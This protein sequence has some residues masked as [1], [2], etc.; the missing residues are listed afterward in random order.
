MK[1]SCYPFN[2]LVHIL[3]ILLFLFTVSGCASSD[4]DWVKNLKSEETR[5]KQ[6][7]ASALFKELCATRAGE[8]IY[9]TTEDVEGILL[10]KVRPTAAEQDRTDQ[11][12]PGAAFV[13]EWGGEEYI[14]SFLKYERIM[15]ESPPPE[16]RGRG[17]GHG[18]RP[19]DYPKERGQLT[20]LPFKE[21]DPL[22]PAYRYVDVLAPG[23]TPDSPPLRYRYTGY[24]DDVSKRDTSYRKGLLLFKLKKELAPDPTPRYAVTY[25][26]SLDPNE[27]QYWIAGSTVKVIDTHTNTVMGE[28]TRYVYDYSLGF[29]GSG[30]Y[31]W[32]Q[33]NRPGVQCPE[34]EGSKKTS[35]RTRYFVDQVLKPA[36]FQ[37]L[38][39]F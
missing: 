35:H 27:R 39:I 34:D 9:Q 29:S 6:T 26:D 28:F 1:A 8:R 32:L 22:R 10:L 13:R 20:P 15:T 25:E 12:L 14:K 3:A 2:R 38:P 31:P 18:S 33:A 37:P 11:M 7:Q 24:L 21:G 17:W 23:P 4:P 5:A 19:V 16:T 30:F 36:P